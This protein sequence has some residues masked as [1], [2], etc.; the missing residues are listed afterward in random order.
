MN[1][2]FDNLVSIYDFRDPGDFI[3]NSD[4][5]TFTEFGAQLKNLIPDNVA[6]GATYWKSTDANYG[7]GDIALSAILTGNVNIQGHKAAFIGGQFPKLLEYY[8]TNLDTFANLIP[9]G[10]ITF[11]YY[12]NYS[13][14]P[15]NTQYIF[16]WG[17][18]DSYNE[19]ILNEET[20]Q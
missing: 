3:Y 15:K 5:V 16:H 20:G 1:T 4:L 12:P 7:N 14:T 11:Q 8:L 18:G 2:N 19:D 9:S 10:S 13:G 6:L 17:I